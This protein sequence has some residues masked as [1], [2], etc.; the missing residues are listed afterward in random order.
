[1]KLSIEHIV[2]PGDI[3]DR[4]KKAHVIQLAQSMADEEVGQMHPVFVHTETRE[5][6]S[7]A[8]R[9]A[10]AMLLGWTHIKAELRAG[11]VV[12]K[13]RR[14]ENAHRR[15]EP[16]VQKE[17]LAEL[18]RIRA[19]RIAAEPAPHR[20]GPGRPVTPKGQAVREVAK[21][22]GWA[23]ETVR[24]AIRPE[25]PK[26]PPGRHPDEPPREAPTQPDPPTYGPKD[27]TDPRP[28]REG[29]LVTFG[30]RLEEDFDI[31]IAE[32]REYFDRVAQALGSTRAA[33]RNLLGCGHPVPADRMAQWGEELATLAAEV[34]R[35][36]PT[37]LCPYCKVVE[38]VIEGCTGCEARGWVGKHVL[39]SAPKSLLDEDPMWIVVGGKKTQYP[40][41]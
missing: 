35:S 10:A 40:E 31:E 25:T 24:K 13:I 34:A 15:H 38:G 36:R 26:P 8:D 32:V 21:E 14:V 16:T 39:E 28:T 29:T 23:P 37:S 3:P 22:T 12:E 9:I 33:L 5:L 18:V 20:E 6:I 4:Q 17:D 30:L 2:L 41:E 11:D 19:A 1:M 7:G 27:D